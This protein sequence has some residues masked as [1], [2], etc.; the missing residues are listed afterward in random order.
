MDDQQGFHFVELLTVLAIVG[1]VLSLG[2]PLY[3]QY[4]TQVKRLEAAHALTALAVGM[5]QYWAEHNTYAG[6]TLAAL[7]SP[8]SVANQHYRLSIQSADYA[9]YVVVATPLA[10]QAE[11]DAACGK[12]VL[13]AVGEKK[14]TGVEKIEQCW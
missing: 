3:S 13:N 1:I 10:E 2:F 11:K 7:H 6:A 5:E 14:V 4:L 12:L 8:E 9:D